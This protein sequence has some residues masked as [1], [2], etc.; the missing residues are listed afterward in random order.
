MTPES[1]EADDNP[2]STL[3]SVESNGSTPSTPESV[4]KEDTTHAS[5][6]ESENDTP[7]VTPESIADASNPNTGVMLK[8]EFA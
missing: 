3:E 5:N 4:D 6:P 7:K 2:S 8:V 1:I